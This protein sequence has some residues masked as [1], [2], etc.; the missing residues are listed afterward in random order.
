MIFG[1]LAAFG[2]TLF[3]AGA[4]GAEILFNVVTPRKHPIFRGLINPWAKDVE[5]VTKG[6]V[7]VK[8]TTATLAPNPKQWNMVAKG[9]ADMAVLNSVFE[10]NR[11]KLLQLGLLPFGGERAEQRSVALWRTQQK[12]FGPG[13][14]F[15][16]VKM[17]T[18]FTISA[19][20]IFHTKKPIIR[21]ADLEKDKIWS[22][23]GT[24]NKMVSALGP[25]VVSSSGLKM[26]DMVSKG[27][28]NGIVTWDYTLNVFKLMPYIKYRTKI[29]NGF[30]SLTFSMFMN[31]KTWKRLPQQDKD[32]IVS[33]SGEVAARRVGKTVDALDIKAG[34]DIIKN[35]IKTTVADAK[36]VAEMKSRLGFVTKDWLKVAKER[37]VDGPAAL[38]YFKSQL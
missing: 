7:K 29:P 27:V 8:L 15:K 30:Y 28:V 17:L 20:N 34:K 21:V 25:V 12:F 5:R 3:P 2:A 33:V 32:A 23:A 18:V 24:I 14:E 26:F 9:I 37:G 38:A 1:S 22:N 10:R 19:T 13:N 36:F 6:R 35:G 31:E 4:N 11:L 16:G